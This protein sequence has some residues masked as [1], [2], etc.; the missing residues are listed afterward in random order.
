MTIGKM[1]WVQKPKE[2]GGYNCHSFLNAVAYSFRIYGRCLD[3]KE[4]LKNCEK[5]KDFHKLLVNGN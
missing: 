5:T 3:D 1:R 4:V 2:E